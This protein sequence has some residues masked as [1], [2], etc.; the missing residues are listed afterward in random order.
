[1]IKG[2]CLPIFLA[3][4]SYYIRLNFPVVLS[5]LICALNVD[6]ILPYMRL[7]LLFRALRKTG[8]NLSGCVMTVKSLFIGYRMDNG[9]FYETNGR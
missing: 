7:I 4:I 2:V 8:R 5:C 3:I 9:Q 6:A 1:M